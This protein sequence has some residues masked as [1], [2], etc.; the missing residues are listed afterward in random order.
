[1]GVSK[2]SF[3]RRNQACFSQESRQF[4]PD[5][6]PD[7]DAAEAKFKE[8]QSAYD[9]IG[10]AEARRQHD[11]QEQ[12]ANMFGGQMEIHLAAW[13]EEGFEDIL[14]QMFQ[15]GK[16]LNSVEEPVI[17]LA[18]NQEGQSSPKARGADIKVGLEISSKKPSK[19]ALF[20][21]RSNA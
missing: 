14:G 7:S 5:R 3:R 4:H 9:K 18:A 17:H 16:V 13:A 11:Q 8:V 20:L 15:G 2:G 1:M 6:N 10:S 21:S 19:V 12:M